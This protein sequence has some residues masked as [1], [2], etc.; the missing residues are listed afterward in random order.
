[1]TVSDPSAPV[2]HGWMGY[3]RGCRCD[4][5]RA[6]NTRMYK[7]GYER[8]RQRAATADFQHGASGYGNWG[9]RCETCTKAH[10]AACRPARE[11]LLA[12]YASTGDGGR[13]RW[14]Q[15]E[16]ELAARDDLP[17]GEIARRVGRSYQAVATKR[18][19]LRTTRRA[20][21]ADA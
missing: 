18:A 17:V 2:R 19:A 14:T 15:Q 12:K 10:S 11:R 8:R 20:A 13:R 4:E 3:K 16:L 21:D 5:C 7:A 6:A 1:M 9:C